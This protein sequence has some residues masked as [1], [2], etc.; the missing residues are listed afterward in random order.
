MV[1]QHKRDQ[2]TLTAVRWTFNSSTQTVRAVTP[3][4]PQ[5]VTTQT[6]ALTTCASMAAACT[7]TT[8]R[9]V[10]TETLAPAQ[11]VAA[12]AHAKRD[13]KACAAMPEQ[14]LTPTQRTPGINPIALPFRKVI[15]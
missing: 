11:T 3:A 14:L 1:P 7:K 8:R 13:H 15:S 5:P 6:R 2:T 12:G 9:A 4:A 10:T